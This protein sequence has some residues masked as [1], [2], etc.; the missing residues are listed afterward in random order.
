[1]SKPQDVHVQVEAP[2]V[3]SAS[4]VSPPP[5]PAAV[6]DLKPLHAPAVFDPVLKNEVNAPPAAEKEKKGKGFFSRIGSF[7]AA[8]FRGK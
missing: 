3:F 7:F 4:A 5:E 2:L 6:A 1:M 8:M